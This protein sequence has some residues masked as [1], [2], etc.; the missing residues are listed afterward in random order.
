M[1]GLSGGPVMAITGSGFVATGVIHTSPAL[2]HVGDLRRSIGHV[3]RLRFTLAHENAHLLL[4]DGHGSNQ[5]GAA[6]FIDVLHLFGSAA[7]GA[8]EGWWPNGLQ[9][10]AGPAG[11]AQLPR[12][13]YTGPE[14]GGRRGPLVRLTFRENV[15]RPG[16]RTALLRFIDGILAAL[17]LM[18]VLVLTALTRH[19]DALTF[20]LVIL[21]ACFRY[22]RRE[23]PDDHGSLPI[24]RYQRLLGGCRV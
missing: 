23:E 18:L 2:D 11:T 15:L 21:A 1:I 14:F 13:Q 12:D 20:A 8:A 10:D 9:A 5:S 3:S 6:A 19:L 4:L 16:S 24:C 22:G 17:C 7:W